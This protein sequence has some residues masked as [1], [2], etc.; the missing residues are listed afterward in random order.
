MFAANFDHIV[1]DSAPLL[2]VPDTRILAPL[3]DNLA[4]VIRA[5]H[6]PVKNIQG[7]LDMLKDDGVSSSGVI[8]NDFTENR[9]QG[10]KYGYGYGYGHYGDDS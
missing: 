10:G 4:L 2:P 3:V 8:L 5:D 7:A 1:I 9:F 6:T